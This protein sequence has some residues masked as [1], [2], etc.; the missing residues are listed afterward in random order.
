MSSKNSGFPIKV[1]EGSVT[2]KIYKIQNKFY[3]VRL[4][5]GETKQLPRF[6]FKVSYFAEGR[7]FQKLFADLH[8]AKA[9][10]K[11]KVVDINKGNLKALPFGPEQVQIF[12]TSTHYA[13]LAGIPLDLL[14][15]DYARNIALLQGRQVCLPPPTRRRARNSHN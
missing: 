13:K 6:S 7:R 1:T 3:I 2:A 9:H 8:E 15:K 12:T 5:N 10:A 4:K 14:A 11:Q